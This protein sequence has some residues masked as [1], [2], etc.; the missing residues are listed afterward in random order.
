MGEIVF[1]SQPALR[2]LNAIT[3][4]II[5]ARVKEILNEWRAKREIEI[6][7]VDAAVLI[8]AGM[9]KS[10]DKVIVVVADRDVQIR[11]IMERNGLTHE[12]AARRV[13]AQIPVEE[14]LAFADYIIENNGSSLEELEVEVKTLWGSLKRASAE[15]PF[16]GDKACER[17]DP[18]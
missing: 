14:R 12:E 5:A 18:S 16:K 6:A 2:L 17:S 15:K 13:D 8:E 9:V 10:M 3:H 1:S 11:R 7:V 4:P